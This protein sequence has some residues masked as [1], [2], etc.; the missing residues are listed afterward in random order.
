MKVIA[1]VLWESEATL[2]ARLTLLALAD[3]AHD[4]GTKAFPS[5]ENIARKARLSE[6]G[7]RDALRKLETDGAI[8]CTGATRAGTRIY[9]IVGP[10]N[11]RGADTAGGRSQRTEGQNGAQQELQTAPDPSTDPSEPVIPP[12]PGWL[13]RSVGGKPVASVEHEMVDAL[14]EVF[15][16]LAGGR[17]FRGK[18]W[19]EMVLRRMRE[20]PELDREAHEA[21]LRRAFVKPWWKDDASPSVV[22][23]NDRV[24]E[25]ALHQHT[26]G[27]DVHTDEQPR[28]RFT[29]A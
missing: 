23:G 26:S 4:D 28:T 18:G 10:F 13:P 3:Y 21:V 11:T 24:F 29:K 2:G 19:R 7:T 20:H 9:T 5:V 25:K 17:S 14:L 15:N 16:E 6:R 27:A 8:V 22:W 1:W 12:P